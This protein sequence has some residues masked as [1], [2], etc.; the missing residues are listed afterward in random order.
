VLLRIMRTVQQACYQ[1]GACA[2][3]MMAM[4]DFLWA[5]FRETGE[6][7]AYLLYKRLQMIGEDDCDAASLMSQSQT[8]E[9]AASADAREP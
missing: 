6:I 8:E 7:G 4:R 3:E 5:Y 1:H 2:G 9:S